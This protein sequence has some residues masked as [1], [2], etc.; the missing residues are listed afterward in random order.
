VKTACQQACPAGA[1]A[2][3][4]INDPKSQIAQ[5]EASPRVFRTLEE[6]H[7]KPN[8]AYMARIRNPIPGTE[9][10]G[11]HGGHGGHGANHDEP[12]E[13]HHA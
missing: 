11:G 9:P 5:W 12:A 6:L 13:G 7:V 8:V 3:G 1:I 4:D 2:F 10:A